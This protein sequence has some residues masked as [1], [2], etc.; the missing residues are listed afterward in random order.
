MKLAGFD[1]EC[2]P[3]FVEFRGWSLLQQE[4]LEKSL[5]NIATLVDSIGGVVEDPNKFDPFKASVS[6]TTG[7]RQIGESN[8]VN[9]VKTTMDAI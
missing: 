4:N 8:V 1:F 7:N 2:N 9:K 5:N 3:E 6:S